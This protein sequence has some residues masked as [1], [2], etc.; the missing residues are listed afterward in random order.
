MPAGLVTPLVTLRDRY[1]VGLMLPRMAVALVVALV[2]LLAERLLR[3]FDLI[4]AQGAPLQPVLHMMASLVPHYLGLALPAAFAIGVLGVV[5]QL[6][7]ANEIDALA[8]TGWSLRRIGAPF[9]A[10]A[11]VL[12][13][14]SLMLSGYVQPYAR[15]AYHAVRHEVLTSGWQGR[16][17]AGTFFD[18]GEGM[19]LS[20]ESV[21]PHGRV[22]HGVVLLSPDQD[23]YSATTA[24][25]GTIVPDEETATV[26]LVL[27]DGRTLLAD[28]SSVDFG[29]LR[30][31]RHF[32]SNVG[33]F[34]PRGDSE[35]EL[36]LAELWTAMQPT[37]AGPAEPRF[38]AEFH[39]RLV[40]AVSLVGV[41]LLA[42][43]LAVASERAANWRRIALAVAV[44]AIFDNLVKL[45][46][47][48]AEAGAVDPALGLWSVA[49][50]FNGAGLLVYVLTADRTG[51]QLP[52]SP[53]SHSP[54][55]LATT[56]G[57]R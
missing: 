54:G 9:V 11:A 27:E 29:Q 25:R 17:Q 47:G 4:I 43:P 34:R 23:G 1:L 24:R 53:G 2:A 6:C 3:L 38:A 44:L 32:E 15:Y 39:E 57:E 50:L 41:A 22:L 49:L 18:V 36:N 51:P 55:P 19:L 16:L 10:C 28:G 33:P 35:R 14:V 48:L 45:V 30:L 37:A 31:A 20:V 8:G 42:V 46:A 52:S 56:P 40:R 12:G 7:E 26:R 21:G 5:R 13:V